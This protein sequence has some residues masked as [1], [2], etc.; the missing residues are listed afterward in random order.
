[1]E[2]I[3]ELSLRYCVSDHCL[4]LTVHC[5]VITFRINSALLSPF[6]TKNRPPKAVSVKLLKSPHG[7]HIVRIKLTAVRYAAGGKV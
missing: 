3:R 1:M 2:T 7:T 4:L 6:A 5:R